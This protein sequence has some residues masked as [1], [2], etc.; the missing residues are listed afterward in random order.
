MIEIV[1]VKKARYNSVD[2]INNEKYKV[3]RNKKYCQNIQKSYEKIRKEFH[4]QWKE[5]SKE[6]EFEASFKQDIKDILKDKMGIKELFS[7]N[8]NFTN[9]TYKYVF[10]YYF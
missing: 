3:L 2:E 10:L 5:N 8:C 4:E 1:E 9:I 7:G 6:N